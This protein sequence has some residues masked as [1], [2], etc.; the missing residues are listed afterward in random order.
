MNK[1]KNKNN[2]KD[3]NKKLLLSV[4]GLVILLAVAVTG[5]IIYNENNKEV[6]DSIFESFAN[7]EETYATYSVYILREDDNLEEVMAKYKT[8]RETIAEYNDLDNLKIG[9]KLIIPTT[10]TETDEG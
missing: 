6:M 5:V 1:D 4:I 7:T 9:T 8:N 2:E 3:K 10:I